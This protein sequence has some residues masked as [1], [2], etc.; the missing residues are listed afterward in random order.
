MLLKHLT[1]RLCVECVDAVFNW[2][3]MNGGEEWRMRWDQELNPVGHHNLI[4]AEGGK[5]SFVCASAT[6]AV[7]LLDHPQ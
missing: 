4:A 6:H 7:V 1:L 5:C 2:T 3:D